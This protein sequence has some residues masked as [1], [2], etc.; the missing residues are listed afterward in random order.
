M[1]ARSQRDSW[2]P[3]GQAP[4]SLSCAAGP[5]HP[6]RNDEGLRCLCRDTRPWVVPCPGERFPVA[7]CQLPV[8]VSSG[9]AQMCWEAPLLGVLP[10]DLHMV[11]VEETV[12]LYCF[13]YK[14]IFAVIDV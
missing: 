8:L 14:N 2:S 11:G 9:G 3:R 6:Q 7:F 13:V 4:F 1:E 12:S 10:G 5:S